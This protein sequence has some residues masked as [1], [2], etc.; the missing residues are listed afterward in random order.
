MPDEV[1]A[2]DFGDLARLAQER[3][4][5]IE[6]LRGRVAE[7]ERAADA[8]SFWLEVDAAKLACAVKG[9]VRLRRGARPGNPWWTKPGAGAST[10]PLSAEIADS[11]ALAEDHSQ[12]HERPTT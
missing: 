11:G 1:S 9:A 7:L 5:E 10:T 12:A 6:R 4:E 2:E 8:E 3:A